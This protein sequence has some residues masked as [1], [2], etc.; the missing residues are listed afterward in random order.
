[1]IDRKAVFADVPILAGFLATLLEDADVSSRE[2][3]DM[4][5]GDTIWNCPESTFTRAADICRAFLA[6]E[7]VA[8]MLDGRDDDAGG[9]LYLTCAG[10]G[11]GFWDGDWEP[12]GDALTD[13][14]RDV[15][16][17]LESYVGDD[18]HVYIY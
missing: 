8:D 5:A 6:A 9:D 1:M 12:H 14:A 11:A 4:T 15:R 7:G 17:G 10:H 18:G 3:G 13:A 2:A 16:R